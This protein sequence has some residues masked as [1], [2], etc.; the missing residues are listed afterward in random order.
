[1]KFDPGISRRLAIGLPILVLAT[2]L[3]QLS[4]RMVLTELPDAREGRVPVLPFIDFV[5]TWNHGVS[6]SMGTGTNYDRLI[7]AV[8]AVVV[9][10]ALVLWM[11]KGAK[12]LI[13]VALGLVAGGAV[14]NC[15]DRVRYGAVEDFIY[16][17]AGTLAFPAVFNV[18]DSAICVGAVLMVFDSLF[19]RPLSHK[20]TP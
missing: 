1:M 13:L 6:F 9:S 18:A 17:H 7:F 8:L 12:P 11:A 10:A 19:D 20:N 4:K 5:V 2:V 3:D 16:A 14:G 15:I